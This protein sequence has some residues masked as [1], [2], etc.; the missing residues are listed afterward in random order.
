MGAVAALGISAADS[1]T[2]VDPAHADEAGEVKII[3]ALHVREVRVSAAARG[4]G[5]GLRA[6]F[7]GHLVDFGGREKRE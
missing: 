2:A 6:V 3:K 7:V 1:L 5:D 4:H